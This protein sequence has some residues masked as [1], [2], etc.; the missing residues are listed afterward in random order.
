[1]GHYIDLMAIDP[2]KQTGVVLLHGPPNQVWVTRAGTI[3]NTWSELDRLWT[4]FP[5]DTVILESFTS[6]A[7]SYGDQLN[8]VKLIGAI[9]FLCWKNSSTLIKQTPGVKEGYIKDAKAILKRYRKSCTVH[10]YD[11][12]A[13][14]LRYLEIAGA[15]CVGVLSSS[16]ELR[17]YAD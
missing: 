14:A 3:P 13:H 12:L 16:D 8:T 10:T 15:E 11:A 6:T 2:G 7:L 5:S 4:S 17:L 9:E 1:M